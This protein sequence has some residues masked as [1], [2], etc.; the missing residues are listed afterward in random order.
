MLA[1]LLLALASATAEDLYDLQVALSEAGSTVGCI[2]VLEQI[3]ALEGEDPEAVTRAVTSG[4]EFADWKVHVRVLELLGRLHR[5]TA[6][7]VLEAQA[8]K[9]LEAE[10]DART[11]ASGQDIDP[12]LA[13]KYAA[14]LE[15]SFAI[16]SA[17]IGSLH[18]LGGAETIAILEGLLEP[19]QAEALDDDGE[20]FPR[21]LAPLPLVP[22]EAAGIPRF[23]EAADPIV[24]ALVDL[25]TA[26]ALECCAQYF[27][28]LDHDL[29]Q[30]EKGLKEA[31]RAKPA[32]KPKS[33]GHTTSADWE[34]RERERLARLVASYEAR[35]EAML[36]RGERMRE[37]LEALSDEHG[38]ATVPRSAL[39]AR[40]WKSWFQRSVKTL[41][42]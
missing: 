1:P 20:P 26:D 21:L 41:R 11:D 23:S 29:E 14:Q 38:L 19:L 5:A 13:L 22:E 15:R 25:A 8:A 17:L 33:E 36:A 12:T 37:R 28:C 2:S 6:L 7:E 42:E 4:L 18:E 24:L 32:R 35:L 40:P 9:Q 27:V 3:A 34:R 10:R 30:C 31:R 16:R 39:P